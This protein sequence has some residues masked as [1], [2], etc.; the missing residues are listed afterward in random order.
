ME[1]VQGS[2]Q[3]IAD[4]D[5]LTAHIALYGVVDLRLR[6]LDEFV[7]FIGLIKGFPEDAIPG[8][9]KV[10]LDGLLLQD[11]HIVLHVGCRT[12]IL[13]KAGQRGR[14]TYLFQGAIGPQSIGHRCD[15]DCAS[16]VKES[17]DGRKDGPE[18]GVVEALL[19]E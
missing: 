1:A 5:I 11:L 14:T 7:H 9:N 6:L 12:D 10:A 4:V 8:L 3:G 15:I 19:F 2:V 13:R 16:M 18:F 17:T